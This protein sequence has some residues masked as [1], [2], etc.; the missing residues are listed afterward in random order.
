MAEV[1]SNRVDPVY[2]TYGVAGIPYVE[3]LQTFSI[4]LVNITKNV[5]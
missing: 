5:S 3:D 4:C 2:Y 1:H